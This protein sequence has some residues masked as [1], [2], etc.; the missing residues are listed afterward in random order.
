MTTPYVGEIRLFSFPRIPTGWFACDGSL[1]SI[2]NYETL[3]VL[4]GTT[5]GGDG[6]Q[7][8]GLPDLRGQ[9]PVHQGTG[10]GLTPRVLGQATG[11]ENVTLQ[12]TQIPQHTHSFQATT[13]P[14]TTA[15]P[16]PTL[17]TGAIATDHLY[18]N[19]P[20]APLTKIALA[21]AFVE[22]AGKSQPHENLMPTLTLSICIAWA[23][24]FPSQN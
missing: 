2:S 6:T 18:L 10:V 9:I 5:Y 3:F 14:G 1:K 11:S 20:A 17:T 21:P 19:N 12:Q 8:F 22:S 15:T 7:T 13:T 24:I 4:L 16:G 23:G